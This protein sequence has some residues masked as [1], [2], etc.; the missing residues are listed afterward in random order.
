MFSIAARKFNKMDFLANFSFVIFECTVCDTDHLLLTLFTTSRIQLV[1]FLF[2]QAQSNILS[3]IFHYLFDLIEETSSQ[4]III[5]MICTQ[6]LCAAGFF[7]SCVYIVF[8]SISNNLKNEQ[9]RNGTRTEWMFVKVQAERH[10][11]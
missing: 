11:C 10:Y 7:L 2:C 9:P 5:Q 4:A 6:F 8:A 3:P 1:L